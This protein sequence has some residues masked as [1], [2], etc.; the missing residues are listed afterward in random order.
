[1]DPY[2]L[3]YDADRLENNAS[4]RENVR[5]RYRIHGPH[6]ELR[7]Q[8][9]FDAE[10]TWDKFHKD[11]VSLSKVDTV[12][13]T[14]ATWSHKAALLLAVSKAVDDRVV[15]KDAVRPLGLHFILHFIS[16][17]YISW[18]NCST[19]CIKFAFLGSLCVPLWNNCFTLIVAEVGLHEPSGWVG[20]Y[21]VCRG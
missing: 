12:E 13:H 4:N 2:S 10:G 9:F 14:A 16:S 5:Q 19:S 18:S 8:Q 15:R 21:T 7:L 17:V 1:M 3:W 20:H 6:G 11:W